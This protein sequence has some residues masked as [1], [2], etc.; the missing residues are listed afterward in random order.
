VVGIKDVARA[1]EVSVGTVSN[2]L[3]RPDSVSPELRQRVEG[4]IGALGYVRNE[5]ARQLRAGV[6]RTIALVV[7]DVANP[8]FA[9]VITGAEEAAERADALVIVCNSAADPGR[10]RRHLARLAAQQLMG[11][12]LSPVTDAEEP[13]VAELERRG[14]PVVLVDRVSELATAPSVAVDDVRGGALAGEHLLDGGHQRLAFVGGPMSLGQVRD[15]LSGLRAAVADHA[16]APVRVEVIESEDMSVRAGSRAA[17]RLF[18]TW[19]GPAERPTAVFC[20]NDLLALGVLNECVRRGVRV[21]GDLALVGYDDIAFAGA[22]PVPLTSVRQPREQLGR[23]AVELLL[24]V[25]TAGSGEGAGGSSG[26]RHVLFEPELVVRESSRAP[27]RALGT[28]AG[29]SPR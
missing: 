11:V 26:S 19:P 18:A 4:A 22:A 6:S 27:R 13:A 5:S 8:F 2:V 20:A 21:P 10:E 15:R 7:L 29:T 28:E 1:A 12:L 16:G 9:D 23:T 14:T 24:E 3:N 25:V 17:A